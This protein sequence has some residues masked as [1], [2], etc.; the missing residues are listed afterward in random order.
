MK[1]KLTKLAAAA[2]IIMGAFFVLN[3]FDNSNVA[4]ATV[5]KNIQRAKTLVFDTTFISDEGSSVCRAMILGP[6]LLRYEL[7]DGQVWI[8]DK[9]REDSK[10]MLPH[11]PDLLSRFVHQEIQVVTNVL[12]VL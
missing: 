12:Q 9:E 8:M 6:N 1:S 3:L 2:A 5:I 4:F 7:P 11:F 10:L